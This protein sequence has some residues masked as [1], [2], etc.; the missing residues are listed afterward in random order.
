MW[1]TLIYEYMHY[2]SADIGG[3]NLKKLALCCT[4]CLLCTLLS[5]CSLAG[6]DAQGLISPPKANA[7]QQEIH[8]LLKSEDGQLSFA[9]PKSG[10][11]RSAVIMRDYTGDDIEDAIGFCVDPESGISLRFMAKEEGKWKTI[12]SIKNSATQV[13]RVLFGDLNG[14]GQEEVIVGWGAPQSMTAV[15]C[16][17][18]YDRGKIKEYQLDGTYNE[19]IITDFDGDEIQELFT[20]T[21]F[22]KTEEEEG[23]NKNA[24]ARVYGFEDKPK[25]LASTPL[26]DTVV[27]YSG[28]SFVRLDKQRLGVVLEGVLAEGS[29][30]T[31]LLYE[32]EGMLLAPLSGK[33]MQ[34]RYNLFLRPAFLTVS[35]KDVNSDGLVELPL[36]R[37]QPEYTVETAEKSTNYY[38]DWVNINTDTLETV[39]VEHTVVNIEDNYAITLPQDKAIACSE[40][41]DGELIFEEYIY[42][43]SGNL[44]YRRR[45]FTIKRFTTEQWQTASQKE[46][47]GLLLS[48]GGNTVYGVKSHSEGQEDVYKTIRLVTE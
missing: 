20:A 28:I 25:L 37:L 26:S 36:L 31:Q 11:Y 4:L 45:L 7:D 39:T 5:G 1:Y 29:T 30:V 27:R 17:Y 32:D 6:L 15:M 22:T 38:V 18:M 13:D 23:K 46:G 33:I 3:G 43:M 9:Y 41:E 42:G 40:T 14:D 44:L 24:L 19:A 48:T 10:D 2:N 21:V 35:S 8:S 47:F 34:K 16:I 12:A